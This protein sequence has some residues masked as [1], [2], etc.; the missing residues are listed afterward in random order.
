[1]N[2][3]RVP[4][5]AIRVISSAPVDVSNN[6]NISIWGELITISPVCTYSSFKF[7]ARQFNVIYDTCI[8]LPDRRHSDELALPRST[9]LT[10][11]AP[12]TN[13]RIPRLVPSTCRTFSIQRHRHPA[14]RTRTRHL[15]CGRAHR[16]ARRWWPSNSRSTLRSRAP[17]HVTSDPGTN[18]VN[19]RWVLQ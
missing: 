18:A 11:F 17:H 4:L 7:K 14:T 15:R 3:W 13:L 1:M 2:R 12:R 10:L 5:S 9:H 6:Y 16:H 8:A 19:V